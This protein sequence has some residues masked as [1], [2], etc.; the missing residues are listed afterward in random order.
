MKLDYLEKKKIFSGEQELDLNK[1]IVFHH[2]EKYYLNT[3]DLRGSKIENYADGI[4]FLL[5]EVIA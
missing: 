2:R 5:K 1:L 3:S 4:N